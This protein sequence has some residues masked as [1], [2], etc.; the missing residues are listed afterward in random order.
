MLRFLFP[1]NRCLTVAEAAEHVIKGCHMGHLLTMKNEST[2]C[3][4]VI[5][6]EEQYSSFHFHC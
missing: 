6:T 1:E 4:A 3:Q 5:K 2:I